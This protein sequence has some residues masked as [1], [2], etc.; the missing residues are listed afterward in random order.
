MARVRL[1]W[2]SDVVAVANSKLAGT[3]AEGS[4]G[5]GGVALVERSGFTACGAQAGSHP[6]ARAH[7]SFEESWNPEFGIEPRPAG[8]ELPTE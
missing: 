8:V 2:Q 1:K 4:V 6:L 7:R 5:A 3:A